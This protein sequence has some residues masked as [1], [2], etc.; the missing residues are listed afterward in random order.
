M[1]KRALMSPLN[2]NGRNGD[3]SC[4][5]GVRTAKVILGGIIDEPLTGHNSQT[6]V[7]YVEEVG[8]LVAV[9]GISITVGYLM[10]NPFYTKILDIYDL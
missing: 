3:G 10:P 1:N 6:V 7:M 4:G 5:H 8:W 9:Y 2:F